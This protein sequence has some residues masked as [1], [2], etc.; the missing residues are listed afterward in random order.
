M[1]ARLVVL[2]LSLS[3]SL[4]AQQ[5]GRPLKGSLHGS[6]RDSISGL[7]LRKTFVCAS[8]RSATFWT[9][10][11]AAVDSTGFY[12]LDSLPSG[13]LDIYVSCQ[14]IRGAF[15]K[16]LR[17]DKIDITDSASV[18]RDW[19]VL[20][21]GCDS[22]PVRRVTGVFRGHFSSGFEESRFIPCSRD[23]WF[24]PEDSLDVYP[25]DARRAWVS[26]SSGYTGPVPLKWP[27]VPNDDAGNPR[28]YVRWSG[29]VVGPGLYGHLGVSPF[30]FFVERVLEV[31]APSARDCR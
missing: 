13:A 7:A 21:A 6:A 1:I 4:A 31:R 22:R 10:R 18:R 9:S 27:D 11:C 30:E 19:S 8:L 28:Y 17:S 16:V 24:I 26:W 25:Y 12:Q 15:G 3:S 14:V 5:T 2:A 20:S 23:A 29:T